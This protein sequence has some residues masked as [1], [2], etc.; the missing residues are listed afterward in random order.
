VKQLLGLVPSAP[1]ALDLSL[2][3]AST[4]AKPARPAAWSSAHQQTSRLIDLSSRG[5]FGTGSSQAIA[6]IAVETERPRI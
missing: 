2:P 3:N 5:F 6:G 1:S 4:A